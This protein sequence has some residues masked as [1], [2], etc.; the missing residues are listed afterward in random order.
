M[1]SRVL[2]EVRN[3][4][5]APLTRLFK[6]SVDTATIPYDWKIGE[7][8]VIHRN[9]S[10][11]NDSNYRPVSLTR[12]S[13]VCKIAESLI[14]Y[15]IMIHFISNS[16]FSSKQFGYI[17]GRSTVLQL[18]HVLDTWGKNLEESGQIDVT[19]TDFAKAIDK[20]PHCRLISEL[21]SYGVHDQ[22]ILWIKDFLLHRS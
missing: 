21:R 7:I 15:H 16:L 18:L 14:R 4:I 6:L 12:L 1:H 20:V 22:L 19:Y 9:G 10:K 8:T 13:V 3:E 5:V 2:F 11:A 17:K